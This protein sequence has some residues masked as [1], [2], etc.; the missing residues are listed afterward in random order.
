[1]G[2]AASLKLKIAVKQKKH[3][4]IAKKSEKTIRIMVINLTLIFDYNL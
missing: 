4:Y 1:M 3:S 2:N